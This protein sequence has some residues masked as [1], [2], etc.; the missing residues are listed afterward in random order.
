MLDIERLRAE[1]PSTARYIHMNSAG[2]SPMPMPVSNAVR[3][4]LD[5]ED[6]VGGYVAKR[7]NEAAIEDFYDAFAALLNAHRDEIA[8]VEN[9]TRAWD[10]AV[11]GI[12]FQPGDR[13]I[14]GISEYASNYVAFLHLAK[15]KGIVIDVAENDAF[16]QISCVAIER[17]IGPRT[18]LIAITH[19]PTQGGLV[20]PAQ[21]IGLIARAHN[22]LYLLDA[23]QSLG[24]MPIDVKAI[25]CDFL[26][27][28]GRKFL[29]GP[30]GT[31]VLY[32]RRDVIQ[33]IHPPFI[34]AH[35]A[36]WVTRDEYRLRDDARRFEN[37]ES[38][39]AGKIGLAHAVRY[40]LAIGLEPI[41]ARIEKLAT[42]MRE[43]LA[44]DPDLMVADLGQVRCG[45]VTFRH[46]DEDPD[47]T[48]SRLAAHDVLGWQ[49]TR[50]WARLDFEQRGIEKLVRL[51]VHYF[52]TE[53]EID[54]ACR[55]VLDHR[56]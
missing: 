15:S 32:V 23:C 27:S 9:A 36:H 10:M 19:V 6:E 53:D 14:T 21:A 46:S 47:T 3:A 38:H 31:G 41:R 50:D 54:K 52:N 55:I 34:D 8:F 56:A 22:I 16:G 11:Y 28:T 51:S 39:L 48:V 40:A 35:A 12:D 26:S 44:T 29:R 37:W 13:I 45:I 25:G 33:K 43:L 7:E 42:R 1:T 2:A 30:R 17:L 18:K 49:S 4:H 5:R 24:Q 20:N